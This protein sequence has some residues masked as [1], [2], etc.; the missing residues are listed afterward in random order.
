MMLSDPAGIAYALAAISCATVAVVAWRRRA[1]NQTLALSLSVAMAGA[2]WWAACFALPRVVPTETMTAVTLSAAFPGP[3]ITAAAFTCLGLAIARPQWVPG[4]RLIAALLVE[5]TLITLATATNPWHLLVYRG[6]GAAHLTSPAKWTYGPAFWA[7]TWFIYLEMIIGLGAV[8]WAWWKAPPAFR[9]QRLAVFVAALVPFAANAVFIVGGLTGIRD[10]TPLGLAVTGTIVWYAV[11]RQELITFSPV[12]RALLVDQIGD[13]VVVISPGGRVL[14]LNPAAVALVRGMN[15]DAPD[16]LIGLR[17]GGLF[18]ESLSAAGGSQAEV[19]VELPGGQAEFQVRSSPLMDRHHKALGTVL[20][21]RD[22]TEANALSRRLAQ[23]H[24]QLVKQVETIDLLRADLVELAGTDP[25]TGLHNRRHLVERFAAMLAAAQADQGALAVALFDIDKFKSVN[26]SFGHS[27]GDAV[28]VT[29]GRRILEHAPPDA[30]VARWGGEEF[31]VAL[32]G[33]DADA[34]L[35]FADELRRLCEQEPTLV[36]GR[37]IRCTISGGVATFPAS[38]TTMDDLFQA[39]DDSMY[40][41]K[42]AGRN[43]VRLHRAPAPADAPA[44]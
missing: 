26:D 10:P 22:V 16:K 6:A 19:V 44:L 36:A 37:L 24:T 33:A 4:R 11:F 8:G 40:E 1:H 5:P 35:A 39:A 7:D 21:A 2:C 38:G 12:A 23:A 9:G 18:G 34:G 13:A 14:D 27:A 15:P 25:L 28:L 31:F 42:S 32:P 29:L 3:S 20:V 30:L 41:A 43:L 17:A